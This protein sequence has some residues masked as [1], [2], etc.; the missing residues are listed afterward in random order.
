MPKEVSE[1]YK[2]PIIL[3]HAHALLVIYTTNAGFWTYTE[4]LIVAW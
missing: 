2:F 3:N 4:F 1:L